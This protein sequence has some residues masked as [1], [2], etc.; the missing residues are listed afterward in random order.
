M[1]RGARRQASVR[2][3]FIR[4]NTYEND[5]FWSSSFLT[6]LIAWKTQTNIQKQLSISQCPTRDTKSTKIELLGQI[7]ASGSDIERCENGP[8][9]HFKKKIKKFSTF[10]PPVD[11]ETCNNKSA[12]ENTF[13]WT[14]SAPYLV[15]WNKFQA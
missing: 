15:I 4:E 14:Y 6:P 3:D 5:I 13:L 7:L 2:P 9:S 1:P 11:L 12:H 10:W 8:K